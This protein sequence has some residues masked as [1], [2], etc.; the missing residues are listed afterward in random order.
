MSAPSSHTS[1]GHHTLEELY[2]HRA[3]LFIAL[4]KGHP[5][6]SWRARVHHDGGG[7]KGLWIGGMRLQTGNISYHLPDKY[8]ELLDTTP[9]ET[10]DRAPKWD[11]HASADVLERLRQWVGRE[12]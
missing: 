8:W 1:D 2:E 4:M 9:I 12:K 5:K 10:L 11:G 6:L 3:L 7:E